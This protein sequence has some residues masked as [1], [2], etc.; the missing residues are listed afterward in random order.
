MEIII[1]DDK[2]SDG[3]IE[4]VKATF[5]EAPI[6]YYCHHP[7]NYPHYQSLK[8]SKDNFDNAISKATGDVIMLCDQDDIWY[9]NNI[10]E[11]LKVLEKHECCISGFDW[12]DGISGQI[13]GTNNAPIMTYLSACWKFKGYGFTMA[14]RSSFLRKISPMPDIAQHDYYMALVALRH[15]QLGYIH[16]SL[17]AHRKFSNENGKQ[18]TS[19]SSNSESTA[20]KICNRLKLIWFSF[21]S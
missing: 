1:S 21:F 19:D 7:K 18:N 6:V 20:T 5:P 4:S 10:G 11:K 2:S 16:K 3:S 9:P 8:R 15:K 17:A 13:I 12:I 14:F